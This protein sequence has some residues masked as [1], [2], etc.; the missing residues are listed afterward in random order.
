MS[1]RGPLIYG[2]HPVS[3]SLRAEKKR[4]D[5]IYLL[6]DRHG[7]DID[8]IR[9]LAKR[10]HTKLVVAER[11]QLTQMAGT[12]K[13]Q[14]IVA[15]LSSEKASGLDEV[16][17]RAERGPEP[18]FIFLVDGVEDPRN[19]GAIIRTVDAAG[20]H[21]VII[22]TRRAAGLTSVVSKT[23]AGALSHLPVARVA[24]LGTTIHQLK[25]DGFWIVG[26]DAEGE[27]LYHQYDFSGSVAIVVG[28]EGNGIHQKILEQCDQVVS[29]PMYGHVS[30]LNV[31]VAVGIVSY[32]VLRQR[33]SIK[34]KKGR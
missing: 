19:L 11:N 29:L 17:A 7:K 1:G 21:G 20:G 26:L 16:L 6:A 18:P 33:H 15:M 31:S 2:V 12:T 23:S 4:L 30:S 24:N 10:R 22:P 5:K 28:G 27:T 32:E 9:R 8:E 13:H 25:K 34:M 3:E 14:G